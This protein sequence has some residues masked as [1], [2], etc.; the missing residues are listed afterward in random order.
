MADACT[1]TGT[2]DLKRR[3]AAILDLP[4][5]AIK[6]ILRTCAKEAAPEVLSDHYEKHKGEWPAK[7]DKKPQLVKT[8]RMLQGIKSAKAPA[9]LRRITVGKLKKRNIYRIAISLRKLVNG[10]NVYSIA[11]LGKAH[12]ATVTGRYGITRRI[13][14]QKFNAENRKL[15]AG[16][17]RARK[18][19]FKGKR[20]EFE[21]KHRQNA[22]VNRVG[23]RMVCRSEAGDEKYFSDRI[24]AAFA[25][26]L[27]R[28]AKGG[29]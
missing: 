24:E 13:S 5:K 10:K 1:L 17:K 8:G 28:K 3:F 18:Q 14:M 9:S 12:S 11:Q 16:L 4:D 22:T 7:H 29:K 23:Q 19:G 6:S 2:I 25:K 27:A 21:S 26:Y 15:N 20:S